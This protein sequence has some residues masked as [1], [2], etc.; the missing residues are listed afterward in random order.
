MKFNTLCFRN[1]ISPHPQTYFFQSNCH[2][3][4]I[5]YTVIKP[6]LVILL[7]L[8]EKKC[9][10]TRS[11]FSRLKGFAVFC[12]A[13]NSFREWGGKVWTQQRVFVR[14]GEFLDYFSCFQFLI[15]NRVQG[16]GPSF[17]IIIIILPTILRSNSMD[18]C[19]LNCVLYQKH[20]LYF[21]P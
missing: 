11:L 17:I 4:M 5:T 10:V 7:G 19:I 20:S 16:I 18:P 15:E 21:A 8:R 2:Y 14:F 9:V 6:T 13:F 3:V 1:R 12:V